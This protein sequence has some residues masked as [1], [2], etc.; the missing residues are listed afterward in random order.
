[1]RTRSPPFL[2]RGLQSQ[3][4]RQREIN[5]FTA[6]STFPSTSKYQ[7]SKEPNLEERT[8]QSGEERRGH[9]SQE[10][11]ERLSRTHQCAQDPP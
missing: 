3:T 4:D 1:M 2:L 9:N 5:P 8:Q 10:R 11:R 6:V 7:E